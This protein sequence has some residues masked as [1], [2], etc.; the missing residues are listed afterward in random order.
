MGARGAVVAA[1]LAALLGGCSPPKGE[2]GDVYLGVTTDLIPGIEIDRV[3]VTTDAG[4][5]L[6]T[7]DR[8]GVGLFPVEVA[9]LD[10]PVGA[11]IS[12]EVQG[13]AP[14]AAA[15]F[16]V[17]TATTEVPSDPPRLLVVSLD[18]AC[19]GI[20][21]GAEQTCSQGSCT[22]D[23]VPGAGLPAYD[24]GWKTPSPCD[25]GGAPVVVVGTGQGDY[26][27]VTSGEV[28]QVEAGPQGGHHV[29]IAVRAKNLSRQGSVTTIS[30]TFPELAYSPMPMSVVFTMNADEGGYCEIHGLRF[31]LD[32]GQAIEGLLGRALDVH[33][34]IVDP[35][36]EVGAGDASIVLSDTV[37]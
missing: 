33:V 1:L 24:P 7:A 3:V 21:C 5:Q 32:T 22:S 13:F 29:W 36:G 16:V 34:E 35:K 18:A 4:G 10:H 12:F 27:P 9:A 19:E 30:G 6:T 11:P 37:L 25:D 14:G 20:S 17:R 26:L 28:L 15:P 8:S 2:V 23:A 31:Q